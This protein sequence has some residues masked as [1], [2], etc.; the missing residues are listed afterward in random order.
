MELQT[1]FETRR[2]IRHYDA[3]KKVTKEQVETLIKAAILAPS[4]KNTQTSR[5]YCVLSEDKVAEFSQKCLAGIQS[6]KFSRCRRV[7]RYNICKRTRW[8]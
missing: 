5:Y 8:I 3:E 7:D 1:A 4:W 2:S 6:E